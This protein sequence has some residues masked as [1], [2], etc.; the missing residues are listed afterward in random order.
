MRCVVVGPNLPHEAKGFTFHVH[1]EGCTDLD[2]GWIKS[3]AALDKKFVVDYES[4]RDLVDHVYADIIEEDEGS[5][6]YDEE[7]YYAPCVAGLPEA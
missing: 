3:F 6:P 4:R 5:Y 7:F 1:A 2:K